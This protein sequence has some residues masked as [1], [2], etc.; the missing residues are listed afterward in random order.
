M[1][2]TNLHEMSR[3]DAARFIDSV[4]LFL[5]KHKVRIANGDTRAAADHATVMVLENMLRCSGIPEYQE[6]SGEAHHNPFIDNCGVCM[7]AHWGFSGKNV[8]V[9]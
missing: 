5:A 7:N 1:K 4:R 9:K 6:C 2:N 3:K 8:K